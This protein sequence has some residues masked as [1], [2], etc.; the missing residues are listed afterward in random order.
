MTDSELYTTW[1]IVLAVGVVVILLAAALLLLILRTALNIR[2]SARQALA[3]AEQ[4]AADTTP[5]WALTE[6]N[7]AAG[8]LLATTESIERHAEGL[9]TVLHDEQ[10]ATVNGGMP[11]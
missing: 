5:I 7:R 2:D 6:T 10:P 4:I 8:E 3:S 9:L 1:F 11:T